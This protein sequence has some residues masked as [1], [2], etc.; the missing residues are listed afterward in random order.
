LIEDCWTDDPEGRPAFSEIKKRLNGEILHKVMRMKEP[1]IVFLSAEDGAIYQK[2][3]AHG[4]EEYDSD[5]FG[6]DLEAALFKT[7]EMNEKLTIRSK[8]L[9][10]KFFP[11]PSLL[12][13]LEPLGDLKTKLTRA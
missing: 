11:F 7:K 2:R 12:T 3:E 13:M 10:E 6:Y 8:K 1:E 5:D 4:D 9:K